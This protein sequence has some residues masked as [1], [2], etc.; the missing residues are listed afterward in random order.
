MKRMITLLTAGALLAVVSPMAIAANLDF[1]GKIQSQMNYNITDPAVNHVK[2]WNGQSNLELGASLGDTLKAGFSIKGLQHDFIDGW[3]NTD[4][5]SHDPTNPEQILIDSDG[6]T[7]DEVWIS[8]KGSLWE[9]GPEVTTRFG[10]LDAQYNPLVASVTDP[11]VSVDATFG[12][13]TLGAFNAWNNNGIETNPGYGVHAKLA[14]DG[15]AIGAT[16]VKVANETSYAIDGQVKPTENLTVSGVYADQDTTDAQAMMVG[17]NYQITEN[18]GVHGGYKNFEPG[19]NP[20]WRNTDMVADIEG[21]F[22]PDANNLVTDNYAKKGYNVGVS[23]KLAGFNI[24]SDLGLYTQQADDLYQ[25]P[26]Q[27]ADSK[28]QEL[29]T[30]ITRDFVF[31][32]SKLTAGIYHRYDFKDNDQEELDA[33]LKYTAPNGLTLE[34]NRD[35]ETLEN[36]FSA[37]L[38]MNF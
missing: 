13:L 16:Y 20:I 23:A 31:G 9:N 22:K 35:F 14:S 6:L 29:E 7:I 30:S 12:G 21:G 37:G 11:G 24:S 27:T 33:N 36:T 4:G 10:H 38:N 3:Q 5:F 34:A 32:A 8:S 2:D 19:F 26:N 1:N 17:A 28:H 15:H 25:G 18:L